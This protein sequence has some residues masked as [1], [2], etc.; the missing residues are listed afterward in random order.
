[1]LLGTEGIYFYLHVGCD[2]CPLKIS[3]AEVTISRREIVYWNEMDVNGNG[4]YISKI[5]CRHSPEGLR[6]TTKTIRLGQ[7]VVYSSHL[8]NAMPLIQSDLATSFYKTK[9][10]CRFLL[11]NMYK[12]YYTFTHDFIQ[13]WDL[14]FYVLTYASF[15]ELNKGSIKHCVFFVV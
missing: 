3:N 4:S 5:L 6:K 14:N 11:Q 10:H 15:T 9:L 8:S 1:M 7:L 13:L 2:R 12:S